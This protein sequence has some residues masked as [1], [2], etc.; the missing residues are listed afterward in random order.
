MSDW[1][2][3]IDEA[4]IEETSNLI[5]AHKLYGEAVNASL[6]QIQG[7]MGDIEAAQLMETLYGGLIAYSQQI[8]TRMRAEEPEI[9]G[10][11][12]AFRAGQA[13]GVSC[14]LNHMIDALVDTSGAT[15]LAAY[16]D[17][18]DSLHDEIVLQAR[19]AGLTVELLDAKG[20]LLD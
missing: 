13:Y 11:D 15:A 7:L 1:K 9:G 3:I 19:G 5:N 4:M 16:D 10:V 12:H 20:E 2:S 8:M 6:A 18:S 14:V 17:F